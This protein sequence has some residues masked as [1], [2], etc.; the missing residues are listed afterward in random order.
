MDLSKGVELRLKFVPGRKIFYG[1]ETQLEQTV[2]RGE[3]VLNENE[4]AFEAY[5]HQ[6]VLAADDDGSGHVVT[7]TTPPVENPG[8][9]RQIVYQRLDPRG[10]VLDVSGMNPTN[11]FALPKEIVKEDS[12]WK[13]EV[14][15][16]LPQTAQ[17]VR[18]V[19]EYMVTGITNFNGLECVNIDC[20]VDEFEFDMPM[21][22]GSGVAKVLMGSQGSMLFAPKEGILA[23]M[24]VETVTSPQVG[25]ITF[26]TS[27][28]I[29][30][31]FKTLEN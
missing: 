20:V 30:Q 15:L 22:D 23:R 2:Q 29:T 25:Q 28:M 17:P 11:S 13:G 1:L 5:L 26:T 3:Q 18:C 7:I 14:I 16:P 27:T 10:A 21:P 8:K 24:E 12:S 4:T 6:R 19:T 31:E 9:D